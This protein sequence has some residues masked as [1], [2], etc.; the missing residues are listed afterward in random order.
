[1]NS[2][3]KCFCWTNFKNTVP[4]DIELYSFPVPYD[5]TMM[6]LSLLKIFSSEP[7]FYGPYLTQIWW[8]QDSYMQRYEIPAFNKCCLNLDTTI[9]VNCVKSAPLKVKFQESCG[10]SKKRIMTSCM[11]T[12]CKP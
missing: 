10:G 3:F 1:M 6:T 4:I 7:G 5:L 11:N 2:N 12:Y 8:L 9:F